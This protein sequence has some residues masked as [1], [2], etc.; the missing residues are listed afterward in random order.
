MVGTKRLCIVVTKKRYTLGRMHSSL[1]LYISDLSKEKFPSRSLL[2]CSILRA[3]LRIFVIL[4]P[5]S[6]ARKIL[7]I[8]IGSKACE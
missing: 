8:A 6:I 4:S 7:D 1:T 5:Q 3:K 2:Y